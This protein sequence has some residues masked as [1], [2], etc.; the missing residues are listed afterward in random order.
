MSVVF[1]GIQHETS[2]RLHNTAHVT[3]KLN[4]I[5]CTGKD[6]QLFNF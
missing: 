6:I 5:E 2:C 1:C 3:L 4:I